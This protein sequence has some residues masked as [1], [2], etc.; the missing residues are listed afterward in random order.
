MQ[1]HGGPG[2]E[3]GPLELALSGENGQTLIPMP[4]SADGQK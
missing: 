3:N 2:R 4:L 1:A